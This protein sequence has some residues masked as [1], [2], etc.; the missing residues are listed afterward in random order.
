MKKITKLL[1]FA[2][3]A[4]MPFA[5]TSC[6]D[7]DDWWYDDDYYWWYGYDDGGW[8]WDNSYY[9]GDDESDG[10]TI[11]DEAQVLNGEWKGTMSYYNSSDG[12]TDNFYADMTFVQN[13]TTSTKGT[14]IEYDYYLNDDGTVAEDQ[15]LK[16]SWYI[17]D[18]GDIYIKYAIGSTFV[19]DI[20]ASEHGFYLDEDSGVF[21]GYMIGTSSND[22][23]YFD[24]TRQTSNAKANIGVDS[25]STTAKTVTTFG[26]NNIAK[27]NAKS[28]KKALPKNR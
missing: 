23:I 11:V 3:I 14:G 27:M 25:T 26:T 17:D 5:F 9:N 12:T 2:A 10:T 22:L 28:V 6:D 13:S 21:Q 7:D 4:A 16:F 19:L 18:S 15:T 8:G 20:S 24:F 1:V